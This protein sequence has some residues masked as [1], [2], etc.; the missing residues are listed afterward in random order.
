MN[1]PKLSEN[2]DK[3]GKHFCRFLKDTQWYRK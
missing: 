3:I 2:C 1:I